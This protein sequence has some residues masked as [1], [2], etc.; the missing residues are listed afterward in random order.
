[1]I[2]LIKECRAGLATNFSL[3]NIMALY[4]LI[5]YTS[6]VVTQYFYGYPADLQ[7]LYWD[8]ACNFFFFLTIGYT[9]SADTLSVLRPSDSLFSVSNV[10]C[11]LVMFIIQLVGQL[12]VIIVMANGT[13]AEIL[14]YI[15][16]AGEDANLAAYH[17]DN[18]FVLTTYEVQSIFMFSNF[19]YV[20][21]IMA[22]S[23]SRP[24]KKYFF[25]NIPFMIVLVLVFTYDILI[26]VVPQARLE[27]FF[28]QEFD[29]RWQGLMCGM[30]CA[31]GIFMYIVQ[32]V[33]LES[34][35]N[36]LR[37][38]YPDKQWL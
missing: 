7:Y 15:T 9:S 24:W 8:V 25:T 4:S 1:M 27:V 6:T 35:F 5:Q 21:S 18:E 36:W 2:D 19:L 38:K 30:G 22:F 32:K 29:M 14:D 26:C 12:S 33:F 11:V 20:F 37:E 10:I 16:N 31:F 23:I 28:L 17:V 34:L 13:F 3:F